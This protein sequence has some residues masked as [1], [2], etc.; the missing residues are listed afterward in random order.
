MSRRC[1][2]SIRPWWS[3][4]RQAVEGATGSPTRMEAVWNHGRILGIVAVPHRDQ[5]AVALDHDGLPPAAFE[6]L[7]GNHNMTRCYVVPAARQVFGGG[8]WTGRRLLVARRFHDQVEV[9]GQP[10]AAV[11]ARIISNGGENTSKRP[12]NTYFSARVR[13]IDKA[14]FDLASA[15]SRSPTRLGRLFPREPVARVAAHARHA[16]IARA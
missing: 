3:K 6:R 12:A 7:A 9:R 16:D 1:S 2:P 11:S 14:A 13:T 8:I 15:G 5:V 4:S 10:I